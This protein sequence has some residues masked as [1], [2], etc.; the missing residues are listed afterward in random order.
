MVGFAVLFWD[1]FN[2]IE[3]LA[4]GKVFQ[5]RFVVNSEQVSNTVLINNVDNNTCA[6][7]FAFALAGNG[8]AYLLAIVANGRSLGWVFR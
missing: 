2:K 1:E 5:F 6:T 4:F 8:Q 3:D 7:R